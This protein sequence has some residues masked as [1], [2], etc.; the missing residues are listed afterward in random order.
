[1]AEAGI[2]NNTAIITSTQDQRKNRSFSMSLNQLSGDKKSIGSN[3][4]IAAKNQYQFFPQFKYPSIEKNKTRMLHDNKLPDLRIS[5]DSL[6]LEF[7]QIQDNEVSD[8]KL[9]SLK[10]ECIRL[11]NLLLSIMPT[12]ALGILIK[13]LE[14]DL[15]LIWSELLRDLINCREVSRYLLERD[16]NKGKLSAYGLVKGFLYVY[17]IYNRERS[18]N[19]NIQAKPITCIKPAEGMGN[20]H[21][22]LINKAYASNIRSLRAKLAK[23]KKFKI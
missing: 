7:G 1:M 4:D 10:N 17:I 21:T 5:V 6:I 14:P 3:M 11:T 8:E 23:V 13:N 12:I 9:K 19:I 22:V 18:Y 2:S 20:F 16:V 15:M